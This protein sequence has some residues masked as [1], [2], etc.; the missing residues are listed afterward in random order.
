DDA[1]TLLVHTA[2][3]ETPRS[4]SIDYS[5]FSENASW[6]ITDNEFDMLKL[7]AMK[8]ELA[9]LIQGIDGIEHAEV[10]INMPEDPVFVNESAEEAS[11]SIVIHTQPGYQ[12]AGN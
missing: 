3:Q 6:G 9:S 11:A 5:C 2:G 4:G 7:D 8:T 1:D 12:F 10:M